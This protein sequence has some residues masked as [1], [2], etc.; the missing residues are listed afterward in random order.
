VA[1]LMT[2]IEQWLLPKLGVRNPPWTLRHS[3][4]PRLPEPAAKHTRIAYPKPDGVLT[5]DRLSSVFLSS[6]N[7]DENQPSHLTLKD[8]SIPVKVNLA[9][10]AGPEARYCP[11]GVYEFVGEADN[12][13][14]RSTR[15]TAL[16]DL[17]HQGPD[18]EHRLGD[19]AGRR[20]PELL[21]HV[22]ATAATAC[23]SPVVSAHRYPARPCAPSTC[24]PSL[25][26]HCS[27]GLPAPA[28]PAT[29]EQ[30]RQQAMQRAFELCAGCHTVQPGGIHRFGPN[31]HGVIGRRAGSLPD[32][33]TPTA[34]AAPTSPGPRRPGCLPAVPT[35][36]VRG[37][38]HVQRLPQRRTPRPGDRLPA[39][40]VGSVSQALQL[41]LQ[42]RHERRYGSEQRRRIGLRRILQAL[43]QRIGLPG[44]YA[45]WPPGRPPGDAGAAPR[46]ASPACSGALHGRQI[47]SL[48]CSRLSRSCSAT[49]RE[50][51]AAA[52]WPDRAAPSSSATA[53]APARRTTGPVPAA[54]SAATRCAAR[55]Q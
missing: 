50:P 28:A 10:Y 11:A 46:L 14:C 40:A 51:T 30:A 31:L 35:H 13:R 25:P 20:R 47:A 48:A 32:T 5:F 34:C 54:T 1:T 29:P 42:P 15:R 6:T 53:S 52:G 36:L 21:G 8:A 45:R 37:H 19:P 24:S 9:E 7:H 41:L 38:A 3:T 27:H 49:A 22:T 18:P 55:G 39:A 12:A 43:D 44:Q 2:G 4:R 17:R 16:Q 26:W 33:A 23:R